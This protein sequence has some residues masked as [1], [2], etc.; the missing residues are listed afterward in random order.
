MPRTK[1]QK[2]GGLER[3]PKRKGGYFDDLTP[4]QQ[5]IAHHYYKRWLEER[6]SGGQRIERWEQPL[7]VGQARR[8]AKNPPTTAWGRSMRSKLGGYAVQRRYRAEGRDPTAKA[9]YIR[10]L[11][12]GEESP[13]MRDLRHHAITELAES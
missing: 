4:Q 10:R 13:E 2:I 8:L 12:R 9:D 3:K 7:L 6:Q 11:K 1:G 5:R